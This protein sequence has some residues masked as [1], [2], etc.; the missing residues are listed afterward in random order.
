MGFYEDRILPF[1]IDCACGMKAVQ[2]ERRKVVPRAEGRVLEI[3]VGSGL[4]FGLYD[5]ARLD[6]VIGVD[7]SEPMLAKARKR[8]A[9]L[10]FP[11]EFHAAGGED[12]PVDAGSVDTVLF[13]YTIC[14]LPQV[15]PVLDAARRALKP[16]GTLL[17]CEHG[18]SHEPGVHRWQRRL[19]PAWKRIAGGCNMDRHIPALLERSGFKVRELT[20]EYIPATP[21]VLGYHYVGSAVVV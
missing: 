6:A 10:A 13:T 17:F 7:P 9:E 21:K 20:T 5:R 3:G 1:W 2:R 12:A 16:G 18:A 11:V 15:A 8:A 4:N 19:N 14:S